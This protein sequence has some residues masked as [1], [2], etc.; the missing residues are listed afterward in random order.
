[1]HV[2]TGR[3]STADV[4]AALAFKVSNLFYLS[5]DLAVIFIHFPAEGLES[6]HVPEDGSRPLC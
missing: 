1:M 3:E 5:P 4:A 2:L 6:P